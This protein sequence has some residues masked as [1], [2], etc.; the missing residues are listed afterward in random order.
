M[1]QSVLSTAATRRDLG[2]ERIALV[3]QGGGALG[4]YQ[5]GVYQALDEAG[6]E[7]DWVAG[8]SI[9][10]VNAALI[11]G[12]PRAQRVERLREFWEL[13]CEPAFAFAT[14]FAASSAWLAAPA[15]GTDARA[16]ASLLHASRGLIAGQLGFFIPRVPSPW[17]RVNGDPGATSVFDVS[18][19]ASTLTRLVDFEHLNAG[20]L[21]LAVGAVNVRSGNFVYF[22]SERARLD[23]RHIMASAALPPSF[24]PVEIDGEHYWDGGLV[25][26]TPLE[27]VLDSA[28]RRD[29]LAFQVDMWSARGR[30]PKT[31][32]DALERE[33]DIRYSSRTRRGTDALA[34]R[35][36]MRRAIGAA[37]DA[38]PREIR[39]Q[40]AIARLEPLASVKVMNV[41]HLIYQAK[42]REGYAKD[43]E[44]GRDTMEE[45][46][47]AGLED[48]RCTLAEP[49]VLALPPPEHGLVTHDVHRAPERVPKRRIEA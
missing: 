46:W 47:R 33:K 16:A 35:Q 6:I 42:W 12:N 39:S 3:L 4:A 38:L 29:T 34:A 19:L 21:R 8:I 17:L 30:V 48:T 22:D 1:Q 32:L 25:S 11:A 26:N 10:A 45:H 37:L 41:I 15:M 13:V 5:A 9:G 14:P 36:R 2:Y 43:Y 28:P 23:S 44:F 49:G 20:D 18:P 40:P 27:Y 24:A 31:L 7:P